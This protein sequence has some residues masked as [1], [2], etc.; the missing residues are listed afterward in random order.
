MS[1]VW[2]H[3]RHKGSELLLL[4]AIAD[5]ADDDGRA[6]PSIARLATKTRLSK[7]NVQ[8]V[9]RRLEESGELAI[10]QGAGPNGVNVYTVCTG[11]LGGGEKIAPRDAGITPETDCTGGGGSRLHGG[12]QPGSP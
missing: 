4:L 3:S 9:L 5:F 1:R 12:G 8:L 11:R 2:E 6:Y 10:E 7:R